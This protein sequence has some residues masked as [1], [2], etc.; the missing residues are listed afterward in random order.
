VA[1]VETPWVAL[2]GTGDV[3]EHQVR[4]H[5]VSLNHQADDRLGAGG[6]DQAT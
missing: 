2:D 1:A 5:V 4:Q 3:L 6:S